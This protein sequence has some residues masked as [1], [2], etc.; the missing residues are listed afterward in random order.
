MHTDIFS[1]GGQAHATDPP[2]EYSSLAGTPCIKAAAEGHIMKCQP[3][4]PRQLPYTQA[5]SSTHLCP[6]AAAAA[7]ADQWLQ[8]LK[9]VSLARP[10]MGLVGP[11]R[12]QRLQQLLLLY[13]Q[14]TQP[15][16]FLMK[17]LRMVV[18]MT[19]PAQQR[20]AAWVA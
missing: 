5:S 11:C 14:P 7:V 10:L 2:A 12:L 15:S 9:L 4:L 13:S 18:L 17:Q 3:V 8:P 16:I 20:R 1:Q 19:E 6:L